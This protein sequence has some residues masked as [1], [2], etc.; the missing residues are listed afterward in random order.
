MPACAFSPLCMSLLA[1]SDMT[2]SVSMRGVSK[3]F[4]LRVQR[5]VRTLQTL[6]SFAHLHLIRGIRRGFRVYLRWSCCCWRFRQP[7]AIPLFEAHEISI[8]FFSSSSRPHTRVLIRIR[9]CSSN[10]WNRAKSVYRDNAV[11]REWKL[12]GK[13]HSSTG[14]EP[15]LW[16]NYQGVQNIGSVSELGG[17]HRL[18]LGVGSVSIQIIEFQNCGDNKECDSKVVGMRGESVSQKSNN[19]SN[20][21]ICWA[22][23]QRPTVPYGN[24]LSQSTASGHNCSRHQSG[25]HKDQL[26][27]GSHDLQP[28]SKWALG[29][30]W[31]YGKD[32]RRYYKPSSL[33]RWFILRNDA[34]VCC[35]L[36][37]W[38]HVIWRILSSFMSI[39]YS[40]IDS[41]NGSVKCQHWHARKRM[42]RLGMRRGRTTPEPQ[43]NYRW[44]WWLRCRHPNTI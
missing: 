19:G 27:R 10:R 32:S 13:S 6:L 12:I 44:K 29:N 9:L 16:I 15:R 34:A 21:R 11:W 39:R 42:L 31:N 40:P 2:G 37:I 35:H 8:L 22:Y 1:G 25:Q 30:I 14:V 5:L 17:V 43:A 7:S 23:L 26:G 20:L 4:V 28:K 38:L 33:W 18:R 24:Y 3:Y 41:D 36:G